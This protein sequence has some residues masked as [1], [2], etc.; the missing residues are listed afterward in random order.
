MCGGT[1]WTGQA[2]VADNRAGD[3]DTENREDRAAELMREQELTVAVV[4]NKAGRDRTGSKGAGRTEAVVD[5]R[6]DREAESRG[7]RGAML[8]REQDS[9][10]AVVA[11]PSKREGAGCWRADE[12]EAVVDVQTRRTRAGSKRT[13]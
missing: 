4:V 2:V 1:G 6:R 3:R 12:M 10:G 5:S 7:E 13:G 11:K 9:T 8:R